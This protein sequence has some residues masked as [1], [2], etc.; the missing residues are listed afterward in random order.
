MSDLLDDL[1]SSDTEAVYDAIISAG[2]KDRFDL[3]HMIE[4]F[5]SNPDPGL[6]EAALKTLAFYWRL[7]EYEEIARTKLR[8]D[9][10]PDVRA[11]AALALGGYAHGNLDNLPLLLDVTLDADEDEDVRDIAY[12]SALIVAGVTKREYP[13]EQTWPGFEAR[14]NWRLLARLVEECGAEVPQRLKELAGK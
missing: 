1:E 4:P 10:D 11:A 13:M 9:E 2:K 12:S 5:L 6:R 14:A 7:P 8:D 3:R